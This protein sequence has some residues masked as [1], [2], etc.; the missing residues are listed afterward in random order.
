MNIAD[1]LRCNQKY[2][3]KFGE[4]TCPDLE[5][6][7]PFNAARNC[8]SWLNMKSY[9]LT[10]DSEGRNA[11]TLLKTSMGACNFSLYEF[12]VWEVVYTE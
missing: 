2:G 6:L 11:L 10:K 4:S 7:E 3:P 12:E 8:S 1:A 9:R 5:I